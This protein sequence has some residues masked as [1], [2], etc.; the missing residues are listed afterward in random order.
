[1]SVIKIR[2]ALESVLNGIT[3]TLSTSWE[4]V[5]FTPVVGVPFQQVV[6]DLADPDNF[7][8]GAVYEQRGIFQINLRYPQQN[9]TA[10]ANARAELIKSTFKRGLSINNAGV[11]VTIYRTP[12]IGT[13]AAVDDRWFLPVRIYFYAHLIG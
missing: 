9:G 8:I 10:D 1:M 4:N 11:T 7:E 6:L 5:P 12:A 13:G 2:G 3:P